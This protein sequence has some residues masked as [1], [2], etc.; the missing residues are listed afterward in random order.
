MSSLFST[1]LCRHALRPDLTN[2]YIELA[3]NLI[4]FIEFTRDGEKRV[5]F[6][7]DASQSI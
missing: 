7:L 3:L 2:D 6:N 1:H 5:E 4:D